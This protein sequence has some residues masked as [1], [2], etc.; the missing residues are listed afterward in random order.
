MNK[1]YNEILTPL[2]TGQ[3]IDRLS[4]MV[5][6]DR[7]QHVFKRKGHLSDQTDNSEAIKEYIKRGGKITKIELTNETPLGDYSVTKKRKR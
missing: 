6:E 4:T 7:G 5:S 2:H 1:S 3:L